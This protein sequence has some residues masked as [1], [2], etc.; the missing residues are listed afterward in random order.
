MAPM[1]TDVK[2]PMLDLAAQYRAIKDEIDEAVSRV[3]AGGA[4]VLGPEVAELERAVAGYCDA[5]H[6]VACGS[7]TDAILLALMALG[8]G[9]GDE[10]VCPSFTFYSTAG[11]VARLGATPIFADVD[12]ETYLAT[13]GTIREA[14][15]RTKRLKAIIAVHLYGRMTDMGEMLELGRELGVPVV[16]D[17]AQAIGSRDAGGRRAAGCGAAGCLSFYPTKNLGGYGDGGMVTAADAGVTDRLSMLHMLG[18][19]D[20][21]HH[22]MLGFNSRLDALHAAVLNVKLRYL[23][24]WNE[25]R[26]ANAAHYDR[27][28]AAAGAA[29]SASPQPPEDFPLRTPAPAPAPAFHIYHQYV[30]RVPAELRDGLRGHLA[31]RGIASDVYYPIPLHL[32]P[33]FEYLGWSRGDLPHSEA[34]A[35]ETLAIPVYPELSAEQRDHV[36]S[37]VIEFVESRAKTTAL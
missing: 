13:A 33:C 15:G 9:P 18:G 32:Q 34:A 24:R 10:V 11:S 26:R 20:K 17:A 12:P 23:D 22:L 4:F 7:G 1:S 37:S 5:A 36:T 25:Q 8:V 27:A 31:D 14:A 19:R 3:I 6:A 21:Y 35:D 29:T 16:E 28:F 30:V 2:V